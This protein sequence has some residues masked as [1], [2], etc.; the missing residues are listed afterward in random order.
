LELE[1]STRTGGQGWKRFLQES[2]VKDFEGYNHELLFM[3]H[4]D[5]PQSHSEGAEQFTWSDFNVGLDDEPED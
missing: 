2:G 5:A 1:E 3:V 4:G